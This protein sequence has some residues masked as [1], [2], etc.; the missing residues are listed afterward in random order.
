MCVHPKFGCGAITEIEGNKL[1]ID[2]E[3]AGRKRVMV[4]CEFGVRH[5]LSIRR[6]NSRPTFKSMQ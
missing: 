4:V 2:F 5:L 6:R 3:Q 1:E